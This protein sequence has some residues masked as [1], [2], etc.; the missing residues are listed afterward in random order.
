MVLWDRIVRRKKDAR[1]NVEGL[2]NKYALKAMDKKGFRCVYRAFVSYTVAD[3]ISSGLNATF[4]L[5]YNVM[6]HVGEY[7][8]STVVEAGAD[9]IIGLLTYGEAGRT[10][11][12][13]FPAPNK[14]VR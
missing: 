7:C 11:S 8:R 5:Q 2:K 14:Q 9:A 6:P 1:I 3:L 4:S 12:M 13:A 10:G